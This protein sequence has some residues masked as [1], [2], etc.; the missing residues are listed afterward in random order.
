M[1]RL[2]PHGVAKTVIVVLALSLVATATAAPAS[3]GDGAPLNDDRRSEIIDSIAAKLNDEYVFPDVARAMAAHIK[4]RDG[5]N[6]YDRHTALDG[7]LAALTEDL[8]SVRRDQHLAIRVLTDATP[9]PSDG[10]EMTDE[11]WEFWKQ[12]YGYENYGI[13]QVS[14]LDGNVGYID[15]RFWSYAE[16]AADPTIAALALVKD[17]EALII[18]VRRHLGGR[19]YPA[20]LVLSYLFEEPVR[21]MTTI[22]RR[23]GIR[24]DEWTFGIVPGRRLTDIPVYVLTSRETASGGE[25]LPFA[26]KNAGR[27][28]VIGEKT[29]GAGARAHRSAIE[30]LGIEL[31]IP[32]AVDVDPVTGAGWD[33]VGVAPDIRVP[34][35]DALATAHLLALEHLLGREADAMP[36]QT[37]E[38]KWTLTGKRAELERAA[39]SGA[40][41]EE[42]AG[43]FDKRKTWVEDDV[44][45]YQLAGGDVRRLVPMIPDWFEFESKELYYARLRFERNA[46]GTVERLVMC[47]DNGREDAFARTNR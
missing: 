36:H 39:P 19:V 25:L 16:L 5:E 21:F 14:R 27:A 15:F 20:Q 29:R 3:T 10:D 9:P 34:A 41:L 47:Y 23:K 28:T 18:D 1:R 46:D 33:G 13:H 43:T 30:E 7:F 4:K 31:Y 37:A 2:N 6:A 45:R 42:Y 26:L 40:E 11:Q 38:R 32:H 35:A 22:D 44:L 17:V 12:F 24:R 8:Q